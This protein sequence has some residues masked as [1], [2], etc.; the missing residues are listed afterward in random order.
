MTPGWALS[1]GYGLF[2]AHKL[3]VSRR[4]GALLGLAGGICAS[5]GDLLESTIKRCSGTADSG[6][7]LP[8]YGGVLDRIDSVLAV[9]LLAAVAARQLASTPIAPPGPGP[10]LT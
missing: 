4:A 6:K 5:S 10:M 1:A 7:I 8:G 3:G 9:A 2:S